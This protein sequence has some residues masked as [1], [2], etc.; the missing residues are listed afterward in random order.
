LDVEKH[1][2]LKAVLQE[3][4]KRIGTRPVDSVFLTPGTEVAV[5]E[6][7]GM[8]KQLSG[9][10]ERCLVLGIAVLE[11]MKL[12]EL[13]AVLAHEYG[14][15]CNEDTAGGGFALAVRRSLLKLAEGLA[16]GGAAAWYNPAWLFVNGFFRVFL[17]I[18]QGASRLQEVLAD[19]WAAFAYGSKAFVNG[20]RHV[21]TRSVEFDYHVKDTV[22]EVLQEQK[23]LANLYTFKPANPTERQ[24]LSAL[25]EEALETK[26]TVYDSHPSPR[27]R[28]AW[29]EAL[30]A[31]TSGP[32]TGED[33]ELPAWSLFENPEEIQR[34]M[35]VQVRANL[36]VN[37][38]IVIRG[39]PGA[40]G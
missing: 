10:A 16:R 34:T 40:G 19:R 21:I 27:E 29:V 33:L 26:A 31:K 38:D 17:R 20:L 24:V 8:A 6:R 18:S 36:A 23:P 37:A 2:R 9:R 30:N 32:L 15:F 12:N 13:K 7:G 28:F 1:P 5:F 3:V 35:T 11:G 22:G 14:H 4:A 25:L 39:E